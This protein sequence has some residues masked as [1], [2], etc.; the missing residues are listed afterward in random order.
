MR[1]RAALGFLLLVSLA[2]VVQAAS[3]P[4]DPPQPAPQASLA[5]P[6]MVSYQGQVDVDGTP[7]EGT[8]YFKLAI[9]DGAGTVTYW[10]HDG[11][12]SAGSQPGSA[13][14]LLVRG[15]RFHV[16]LGD[17]NVPNMTQ[18]L[19]A[20][21]FDGTGRYLRVWFSGDGTSYERLSPDHPVSSVPYALQA[22]HA[23]TADFAPG[24]DG[25]LPVGTMVLA[26]TDD[27]S[28]LTGA[29]FTYT[30]LTIQPNAW[31]SRAPLPTHR[32]CM[33]AVA[34]NGLVYAIGGSGYPSVGNHNEAYDPA[35]D[36]WTIKTPM[37]TYRIA[38]AVAEV[39]G[40]VY[41][42]GG[43]SDVPTTTVEVYDPAADLWS[44]RSPLPAPAA[45]S[46]AAV[47]NG[48]IYVF[49][50]G[51]TMTYAYHPGLD[52]WSIKA[53][54]PTLRDGPAAAVVDGVIYV[55]GGVPT[56]GQQ[57]QLPT[58]EAYDPLT[59]SWTTA[60]PM[61]SPKEGPAAAT[62]DGLI[63]VFGGYPHSGS[64][65]VFDPASDAWT[66]APQMPT[67]RSRPA[68]AVL[69]GTIYVIGGTDYGSVATNEAFTPTPPLYV[70]R[71]G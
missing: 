69:D 23:A 26:E 38:P 1:V 40:L 24:G 27:D 29:G 59:N 21:V 35:T 7:F 71:K 22:Q 17:T 43:S 8:G 3:Q 19:D 60:A 34:V 51:L 5:A 18:P 53:P 25:G 33:A 39:N 10:S 67:E 20:A 66:L 70:Y 48:I 45:D 30:G 14:Q 58:N 4:A 62:L 46:A 52:S 12:S 64:N 36:S 37:P 6:T 54:M 31:T 28:S 56:G 15:G 47:V 61:P 2:A 68:A 63:Y 65:M 16:L 13:L 32:C 50:G 57:T 9:V 49:G 55:M 41:V 11:T 42:I 44:S